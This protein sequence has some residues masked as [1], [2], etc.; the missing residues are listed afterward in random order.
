MA[1]TMTIDRAYFTSEAPVA[2]ET[3]SKKYLNLKGFNLSSDTGETVVVDRLWVGLMGIQVVPQPYSHPN[4]NIGT[5]SFSNN[6]PYHSSDYDADTDYLLLGNQAGNYNPGNSNNYSVS[7]TTGVD[8]DLKLDLDPLLTDNYMSSS[9]DHGSSNAGNNGLYRGYARVAQDDY[10]A[11]N[12]TKAGSPNNSVYSLYNSSNT[13]RSIGQSITWLMDNSK[14]DMVAARNSWKLARSLSSL[15]FGVFATYTGLYLGTDPDS[16]N[17]YSYKSEPDYVIYP[18]SSGNELVT[19]SGN[20]PKMWNDGIIPLS[21]TQLKSATASSVATQLMDEFDMTYAGGNTCP[22]DTFTSISDNQTKM[23]KRRY[24]ALAAAGG[25]SDAQTLRQNAV[26]AFTVNE[27]AIASGTAIGTNLTA[28]SSGL[29]QYHINVNNSN[30]SNITGNGVLSGIVDNLKFQLQQLL[31]NA[32]HGIKA[33][34]ITSV[35]TS[36]G[37]NN[38]PAITN[39]TSTKNCLQALVTDSNTISIN[40]PAG[41]YGG[42]DV[43]AVINDLQSATDGGEHVHTMLNDL[44]TTGTTTINSMIH[45]N[46]SNIYIGVRRLVKTNNDNDASSGNQIT[47]ANSIADKIKSAA[48]NAIR[49]A[50]L[51]SEL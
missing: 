33:A 34:S 42:T 24:T 48:C 26:D 17:G 9:N 32:D 45:V 39:Q 51:N 6:L 15:T 3:Y 23:L 36:R 11:A 49:I 46:G 27:H 14:S 25:D 31:I 30:F 16:F 22:T 2:N 1:W 13:V 47:V 21:L 40:R 12:F 41:V 20:G 10:K 50:L 43:P 8:V 37:N 44:S 35:N 18:Y 38:S 19:T 29:K 28:Y 7:V 5:N 4:W